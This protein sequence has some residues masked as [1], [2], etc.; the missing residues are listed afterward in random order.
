[1]VALPAVLDLIGFV[2]V[3]VGPQ[4]H[5]FAARILCAQG[6]WGRTGDKVTR[7]RE[8]RERDDRNKGVRWL[9]RGFMGALT[10]SVAETEKLPAL[11]A[12]RQSIGWKGFAKY[13]MERGLTHSEVPLFGSVSGHGFSHAVEFF[14][15][16]PGA[17][18]PAMSRPSR[19]SSPDE[20]LSPRR[21]FFATTRTHE[22]R[23]LL[24]SKR[25]ANLLVDG[26]RA[27]VAAR[28]IQP[29]DFVIMPNHVHLLLTLRDGMTIEKAMQLITGI[30]GRS[31]ATWVF[32]KPRRHRRKR[33]SLP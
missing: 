4:F 8:S 33:R 5:S 13:F 32:R 12:A 31:L 6:G 15:R 7:G 17:L 16:R 14:Q 11:L 27:C 9:A 22:G 26:L 21:T 2:Q 19:H 28:E 1:V 23:R 10:Y 24:Q 30:S 20:S 3:R 18:A 29:D 25:E